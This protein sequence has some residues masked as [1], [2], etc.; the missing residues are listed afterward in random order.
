MVFSTRRFVVC[1]T[2]CHIVLVFF[3]PFSIAITSL[4][5][6]KAVLSVFRTFDR[7][8]LVWIYRFS[9]PLDVWEGLRFV[10]VAPPGLFLPFPPYSF[11]AIV[12]G[13]KLINSFPIALEVP[14]LTR[15]I[16]DFFIEFCSFQFNIS[17]KIF[18]LF[19]LYSDDFRICKHEWSK[20]K[21][22]VQVTSCYPT[23]YYQH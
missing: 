20:Y 3:S 13:L 12:Y 6:E 23:N 17:V 16:L 15:F 19:K 5:E 7:F 18:S 2:L 14:F 11:I 1:L 21:I 10:I 4:G 8:V 22:E 9:L